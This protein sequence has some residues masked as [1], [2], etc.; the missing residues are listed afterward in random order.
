MHLA[1][2]ALLADLTAGPASADQR[3]L[4]EADLALAQAVDAR[5][6]GAFGDLL[7]NDAYFCS[8]GRP[9]KGRGAVLAGWSDFFRED[10]PKLR[11]APEL[12][13][14]SRSGD[15]G[16]TIGR[17]ELER[18][19]VD[20]RVVTS[21]GRYVTVW[22]KGGDGHFRVVVDAPLLPPAE[23]RPAVQDRTAERKHRSR[24]G[25][26][27]VEAGTFH[28]VAPRSGAYLVIRRRLR[29]GTMAVAL[30]T[31]VPAPD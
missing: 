5:D 11:W 29:D 23:E 12:A 3:T 10:G 8:G 31:L 19:E 25:D 24:S 2:L 20:G 1:L 7:A 28:A 14:L 27:A 16:Y 22:R 9:M 13:E 17:W 30:E 15:L 21:E 18:R 4:R 6:A 26:L